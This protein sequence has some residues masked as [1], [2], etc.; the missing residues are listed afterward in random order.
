MATSVQQLPYHRSPWTTRT[1]LV[2]FKT[3]RGLRGHEA[4]AAIGDIRHAG[5]LQYLLD[6]LNVVESR[7]LQKLSGDDHVKWIRS[8]VHSPLIIGQDKPR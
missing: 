7:W 2:E 1:G 4:M 3:V 5:K 6:N 8:Y